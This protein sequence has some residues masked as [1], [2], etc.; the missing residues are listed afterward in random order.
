MCNLWSS[1]VF[2]DFIESFSEVHHNHIGL[3][4]IFHSSQHIFAELSQLGFFLE[5]GSEPMLVVVQY[6]VLSKLI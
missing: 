4:P 3:L 5:F 1:L 6:V 2:W